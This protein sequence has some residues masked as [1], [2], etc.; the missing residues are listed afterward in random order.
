[1]QR[2]ARFSNAATV[3]RLKAAAK[4]ADEDLVCPPSVP[5]RS[6][7]A[8]ARTIGLRIRINGRD[9]ANAAAG[10]LCLDLVEQRPLDGARIDR[11]RRRVES[12]EEELLPQT[13]LSWASY[14]DSR[15]LVVQREKR[16][17]LARGSV[18]SEQF[19]DAEK[20][21]AGWHA[22]ELETSMIALERRL[23]IMDRAEPGFLNDLAQSRDKL[24]VE[25]VQGIASTAVL[26]D[27]LS[28]TEALRRPC[29]RRYRFL[30]ER[31]EEARRVT[32]L[33]IAT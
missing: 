5:T 30:P 13:R 31:V 7:G 26:G 17:F 27:L 24:I 4:L 10:L 3:A 23:V 11:A 9:D 18:E 6:G 14:Q 16:I 19:L 2:D 33:L 25:G 8:C 12:F 32:T 28:A 22:G 29:R 20:F 21:A 1:L 15:T